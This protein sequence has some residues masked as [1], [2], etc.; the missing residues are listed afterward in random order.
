MKGLL[1]ETEESICKKPVKCHKY[2][3]KNTFQNVKNSV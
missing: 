1:R 2:Q 3:T